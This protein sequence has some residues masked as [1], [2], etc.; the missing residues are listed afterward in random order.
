MSGKRGR[1]PKRNRPGT[2]GGGAPPAKQPATAPAEP[3]QFPETRD[4]VIELLLQERVEQERERAGWRNANDVLTRQLLELNARLTRLEKG[5]EQGPQPAPAPAAAA[6]KRYEQQAIL[7]RALHLML[8]NVPQGMETVQLSAQLGEAA[9]EV[10]AANAL[11]IV[12]LPAK[13]SV[14]TRTYK[15]LCGTKEVRSA[16]LRAQ[17][18]LRMATTYRL[19]VDLTPAQQATRKAQKPVADRVKKAGAF[20]FFKGT[21][22]RV[23]TAPGKD[24][25][26]ISWLAQHEKE[27]GGSGATSGTA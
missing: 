26:A 4:G 5:Q 15:L 11:T 13:E 27:G 7:D 20:W 8:Y 12:P 18:K 9:P 6:A 21:A 10:A 22:L 17:H 16:L 1:G 2:S 14:A 24:E 19:D 3:E 25:D 23:R